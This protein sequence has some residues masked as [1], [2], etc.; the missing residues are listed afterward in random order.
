VPRNYIPSVEQG[1]RDALVEGPG[2]FPVVDVAVVLKDGKHHSV[3][4]SDYAFRTAGK[5][6]VKEALAKVGTVTLQPIMKVQIHVPAVFAGGLVPTISGIKGQVLGFDGHPTAAGWDVFDCLLPMAALDNLF[7]TLAS[8]T[9]GTAWF[10][11][12]FDHYEEARQEDVAA[13]EERMARA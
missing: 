11:S 1:V 6:A 5:N 7:N 13:F 4:S 3:D 12:E 2:G 8:A 9:R 10:T